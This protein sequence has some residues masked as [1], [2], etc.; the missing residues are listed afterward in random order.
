MTDSE[1]ADAGGPSAGPLPSRPATPPGAEP[2]HGQSGGL[3]LP[4]EGLGQQAQRGLQ[5]RATYPS[6]EGPVLRV[7]GLQA[8]YA[9]NLA[10][11]LQT[12]DLAAGEVVG[13][14]GAHGA[15]QSTQV[16]A[17]RGW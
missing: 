13:V 6:H 16:N 11:D 3:A 17:Q 12:L 9:G 15:G 8:S 2:G 1:M 5:G 4:G 14:V 7:R 10:L